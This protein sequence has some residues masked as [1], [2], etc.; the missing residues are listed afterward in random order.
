MATTSLAKIISISLL[1]PLPVRENAI[2]LTQGQIAEMQTGEQPYSSLFGS[3]NPVDDRVMGGFSESNARVALLDSLGKLTT[4]GLEETVRENQ[5]PMLY[6]FG[7]VRR[8]GGFASVRSSNR[9][10]RE[11]LE[12][13]DQKACN[14]LE[15]ELDRQQTVNKTFSIQLRTPLTE[16]SGIYYL[17]DFTVS[18]EGDSNETVQMKLADFVPKRK[19][20]TIADQERITEFSSIRSIGLMVSHMQFGEFSLAVRDIRAVSN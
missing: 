8:G 13:A 14:T 10:Q 20:K 2:P 6:F 17:H 12:E 16:R 5:Y 3:W 18:S 15:I 19:G 1:A 7:E 11:V 4:V 9:P